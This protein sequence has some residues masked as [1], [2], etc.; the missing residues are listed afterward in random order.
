MSIANYFKVVFV[1]ILVSSFTS[2][3]LG[4]LFLRGSENPLNN[5]SQ[6][7]EEGLYP[8]L[9]VLCGTLNHS[10][11]HSKPVRNF[12]HHVKYLKEFDGVEEGCVDAGEL[13][14]KEES[15]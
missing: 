4:G 8:S 2:R 14:E 5:P 6:T 7:V 9:S 15:S 1:I 11:E 10:I 3:N 12:I 13:L